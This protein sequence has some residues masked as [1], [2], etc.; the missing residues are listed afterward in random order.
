[1]PSAIAY[2]GTA[3]IAF[4]MAAAAPARPTLTGQPSPGR[5]IV[6][7]KPAP[8]CLERATQWAQIGLVIVG[9]GS[10]G[11]LYRQTNANIIAADAAKKSADTAETAMTLAERAY[12]SMIDAKMD[13]MTP[14]VPV[15]IAYH[16]KNFGNTPAFVES[17]VFEIFPAKAAPV[18][19]NYDHKAHTMSL[20][21]PPS[22]KAPSASKG[23]HYAAAVIDDVMNDRQGV[24]FYGYFNFVDEFK[25]RRKAYFAVRCYNN[26]DSALITDPAFHGYPPRPISC[27]TKTPLS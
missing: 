16:I 6:L 1:M 12:L 8:D 15:R 17:M 24:F 22:A 19:P 26:G 25:D 23:Q 9:F 5:T 14:G 13:A 21:L 11:F 10:L 3:A 7:T 4:A 20:Y 27:T 18:I 2:A